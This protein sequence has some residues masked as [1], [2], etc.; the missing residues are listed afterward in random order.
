MYRQGKSL[1][2][3]VFKG[4][5]TGQIRPSELNGIMIYSLFNIVIPVIYL[6]KLKHPLVHICM[7]LGRNGGIHLFTTYYM[8]LGINGGIH[9]LTTYYMKL[10]RNGGIQLF[11]TYCMK[12]G[13]NGG[14]HLFMT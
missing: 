10:G 9:L 4:H 8:K 1:F 2:M 13:R 14:I 7:K 6:G 3:E 12:L 11:T 5:L